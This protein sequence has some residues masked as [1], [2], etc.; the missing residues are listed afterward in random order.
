MKSIQVVNH[1]FNSR[2]LRER[3]V[4]TVA[5]AAVLFVLAYIFIIDPQLKRKNQLER[6]F[7]EIQRTMIDL[8]TQESV[9]LARSKTDPDKE[10]R[11][12]IDQLQKQAAKLQGQL[13]TSISNL[14]SPQQMIVVL[15]KILQEQ[16][17]LTLISLSNLTPQLIQISTA[18]KAKHEGPNLYQHSL[19][20]ELRG[21]YRALLNYLESIQNMPRTLVWDTVEIETQDYP[22]ATIRLRISTLGLSE[23]WIG[24]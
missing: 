21:N 23:G 11:E 7:A 9:I 20:M 24:G 2:T 17:D 12:R 14:V 10:N 8:N 4:V 3:I 6:Q 22:E 15:K 19:D 18:D 5:T 13:E 1:W 16:K